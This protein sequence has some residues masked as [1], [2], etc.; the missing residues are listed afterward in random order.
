MNGLVFKVYLR[1]KNAPN[2]GNTNI[3][4][5]NIRTS[6]GKTSETY[7]KAS[8]SALITRDAISGDVLPSN[9]EFDANDTEEI[10]TKTFSTMPLILG[11]SLGLILIDSRISFT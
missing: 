1:V 3:V 11:I 10:T 7:E 6:D 9:Q 2:V 5:T 8:A 4:L